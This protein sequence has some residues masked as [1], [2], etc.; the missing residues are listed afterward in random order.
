MR[1]LL[2]ISLLSCLLSTNIYAA[3]G[4]GSG[5]SVSQHATPG[6]LH[7]HTTMIIS[8]DIKDFDTTAGSIPKGYTLTKMFPINYAMSIDEQ[9]NI[10]TKLV[11]KG[12]K[13][14]VS[15]NLTNPK[16]TFD[17]QLASEL[18]ESPYSGTIMAKLSVTTTQLVNIN[19]ET[20]FS[21]ALNIATQIQ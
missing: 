21:I 18:I 12:V 6:S 13:S 20:S 8:G 10:K 16:V 2:N 19:D 11:L 7:D 14:S 3:G 5:C 4:G 9:C 15:E 1:K 17:N